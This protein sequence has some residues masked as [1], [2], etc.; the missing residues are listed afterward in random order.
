MNSTTTFD[1]TSTS[2]VDSALSEPPS[3]ALL[4]RVEQ[5]LGLDE[6]VIDIDSVLA[7]T[8]PDEPRGPRVHKDIDGTVYIEILVKKDKGKSRTGW[9]WA[10]GTEFEIQDKPQSPRVWV[11]AKCKT[12]TSYRV[13]GSAHISKHLKSHGLYEKQP[14]SQRMSI[15]QQLQHHTPATV[16][17]RL[18]AEADQRAVHSRKFE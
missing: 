8:V 14:V 13:H 18:L 15:A 11:C 2:Q 17:N 1:D 5:E 10:Y 3:T 16:D 12:F 7:P 9:Y 6:E 4:N